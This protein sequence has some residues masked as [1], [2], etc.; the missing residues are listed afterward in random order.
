MMPNWFPWIFVGGLVFIALSFTA[1]KYKDKDYKK[2]QA[3]QDFIS[4]AILIGFTG[5]L[6]PDMFPK[7]GLPVSLPTFGTGIGHDD[8]DLQVGPPRLAGR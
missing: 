8:L 6:V 2:I 5:V 4:G 3:L 7:L 1:S